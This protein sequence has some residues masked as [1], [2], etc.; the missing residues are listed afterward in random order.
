MVA[1]SA[2]VVLMAAAAGVAITGG[3]DNRRRDRLKA[4]PQRQP[5]FP[6]IVGPL[7]SAVPRRAISGRL[8]NRK[9][10]ASCMP[11]RAQGRDCRQVF[12]TVADQHAIG[13]RTH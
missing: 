12:L 3:S 4:S 11:I 7:A 9:P 5:A 1:L 10:G 8:V 2:V 13:A 6:A